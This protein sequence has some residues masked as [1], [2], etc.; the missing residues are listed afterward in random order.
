[1]S[2]QARGRIVKDVGKVNRVAL[3]LRGLAAREGLFS[4]AT[5]VLVGQAVTRALGFLFPLVLAHGVSKLDFALVY[6]F[7]S[8]GFF[9]AEPVLT[10]YP[11]ALVHFIAL[12]RRSRAA[13][14]TSALLGGIPLVVLSITVGE[15]MAKSADA[16]PVLMSIV[17]IGLTIDAYYF[18]VLQG[19]RRFPLLP[20]Y[21]GSANLI[22]LLLLLAA[23]EAGLVSVAVAVAIYSLV[24]LVPITVLEIR[25]GVIRNLFLHEEVR[26]TYAQTKS[27]TKFAIPALIAGTAYAAVFNLDS[28]F[29]QLFAPN[30][31]ADYGAAKTLLQPMGLIPFAIGIVLFPQ[32]S[33]AP[34]DQRWQLL[35]R[36]LRV[37]AAVEG[38]AICVYLLLASVAVNF[39]FPPSYQAAA[40]SLR[41]LAPAA[42]MMGCYHILSQWWLGN[43]RP[44]VPATSL[45]VGALVCIGCHIVMTSRYGAAGAALSNTCGIAIAS[46]ILGTITGRA[47]FRRRR[48]AANQTEYSELI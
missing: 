29:V 43:G 8:T 16:P 40:T 7:I 22:Q 39:V 14:V 21:R 1:L 9:V 4:S 18:A 26:P 28:Y 41:L 13:W 32:V 5:L 34:P 23:I 35:G 44:L 42:A 11:T 20:I 15:I 10:G 27:L 45:S 6:F 30:A 48:E 2:P 36:G 25:L 33:A 3:R 47:A 17:V 12:H 24:Y 46:V 38:V 19:L 37:V 31:L